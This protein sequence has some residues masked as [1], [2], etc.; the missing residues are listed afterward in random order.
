MNEILR[1]LWAAVCLLGVVGAVYS[2]YNNTRHLGP[3]WIL[4]GI[5][6]SVGFAVLVVGDA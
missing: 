4:C 6:C 5:L 1:T 2:A 3:V